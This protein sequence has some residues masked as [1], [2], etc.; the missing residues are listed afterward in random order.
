MEIA[1]DQDALVV[2]LRPLERLAA[3]RWSDVRIPR[4]NV[5]GAEASLP[6]PTWKQLRLP[7][8]HLPGLVKAG[9]YLTHRG[10]EF[11]YL[12]R[13]GRSQPV[14]ISLRGH[15]YARLVLGA[16]AVSADRINRWAA[17]ES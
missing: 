5:A 11:W 6:P 1:L 12:T 14:T 8:T 10:W 17:G 2:K 16:A 13:K 15:R 4:Q 7:G 9:T 3:V